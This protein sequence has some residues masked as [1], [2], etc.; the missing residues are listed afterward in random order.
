MRGGAQAEGCSRRASCPTRAGGADERRGRHRSRAACGGAAACFRLRRFADQPVSSHDVDRRS[1]AGGP[2]V[3]RG[4]SRPAFA[5]GPAS[6]DVIGCAHRDRLGSR[7]RELDSAGFALVDLRALSRVVRIPA[8]ACA[9]GRD[10][11]HD[12]AGRRPRRRFRSPRLR[13]C[14]CADRQ[15]RSRHHGR[16]CR[17]TYRGRTGER[18]VGA[19][20][21]GRGLPLA[22]ERGCEPMVSVSAAVPTASCWRLGK[23]RGN[24]AGR[25]ALVRARCR[26]V[27]A[28]ARRRFADTRCRRRRRLDA[29]DLQ[30]QRR[31]AAMLAATS[32]TQVVAASG[33]ASGA[34]RSSTS[35]RPSCR[36]GPPSSTSARASAHMLSALRVPWVHKDMSSHSSAVQSSARSSGVTS[37]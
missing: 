29:R 37:A 31:M 28:A 22:S 26:A 27:V 1:P 33:L 36:K 21:E 12:V 4:R 20:A 34:R 3:P 23:R 30:H 8:K 10:R 6:V 25:A 13:R 5:L 17:R 35:S 19:V 14:G 32:V 11:R 9:T 18:G 16:Q 15:P 7:R 2:A 24:G